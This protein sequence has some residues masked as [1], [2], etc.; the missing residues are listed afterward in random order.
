MKKGILFL[1]LTGLT[2][3]ASAQTITA[4]VKAGFQIT[5]YTKTSNSKAALNW[6]AGGF[7]SYSIAPKWAAKAEVLLSAQ[8][9]K[10][11]NG[12]YADQVLYLNIPLLAV[13]EPMEKLSVEAGFQPGLLMSA[14][15]KFL[16]EGGSSD[17]SDKY[18]GGDMSFIF[19]AG[20]K[21]M[22]ALTV[23]FRMNLGLSQFHEQAVES[24]QRVFQVSAAY[25]LGKWSK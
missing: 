1:I 18:K 4:G 7:G 2:T 19:G 9:I 6:H 22:D 16:D 14:K 25:D 15:L 24:R 5:N 13:F 23:S 11:E 10:S 8:G 12:K 20:Y 21:V 17:R 3:F